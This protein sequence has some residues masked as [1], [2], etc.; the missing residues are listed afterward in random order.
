MTTKTTPTAP[1]LIRLQEHILDL[2]HGDRS[3]KAMVELEECMVTLRT[4]DPAAWKRVFD[5]IQL[6]MDLEAMQY[7]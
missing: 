1:A 6:D 5:E 3:Q 7:E 2:W 4:H